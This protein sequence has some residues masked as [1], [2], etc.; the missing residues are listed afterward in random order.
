[1]KPAPADGDE[2]Q[3]IREAAFRL[4]AV[5]ARSAR[6]LQQ[7]LRQKRFP[8]ELVEQVIADLQAKGY[9]SDEE[10]ARQ[11]AREKWVAS[12]WGPAR[13]RRELRARGISSELTDR[14]VDETYADKDMVDVLLPLARKRWRTTRGLPTETRRRRLIG[15]LQRR[16][17]DWGTINQ[18]LSKVKEPA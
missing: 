2:G 12:G 17:Y 11:Y 4:L 5:R 6:E 10:F 16:G 9:Q 18:V 13:V 8:P 15:F 1:M 7:R 14:V 3:R